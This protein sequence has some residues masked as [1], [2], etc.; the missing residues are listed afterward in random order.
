M[1]QQEKYNAL[2]EELGELIS[3]KNN[4]N[5]LLRWQLDDALRK[6]KEVEAE[7]EKLKARLDGTLCKVEIGGE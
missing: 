5:A 1:T 7:N 2:L 6:L 3:N 4:D